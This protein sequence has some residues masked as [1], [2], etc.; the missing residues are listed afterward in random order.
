MPKRQNLDKSI[1]RLMKV[2]DELFAQGESRLTASHVSL[3][4]SAPNA[5]RSEP[6][7]QVRHRPGLPDSSTAQCK[8]SADLPLLMIFPVA[9]RE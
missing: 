6:V 8:E 9:Q 1:N 5:E 7:V 4:R 2:V 3:K